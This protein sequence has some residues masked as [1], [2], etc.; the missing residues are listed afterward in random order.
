MLD[1]DTLMTYIVGRATSVLFFNFFGGFE[2]KYTLASEQP[3][4]TKDGFLA[5]HWKTK[6]QQVD[7]GDS[8]SV[9][10]IHRDTGKV[11]EIV[12]TILDVRENG[13]ISE[14]QTL[15]YL[16]QM[17]LSEP[18]VSQASFGKTVIW[19]ATDQIKKLN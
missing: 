8:V 3:E 17:E 9:F 16:F 6:K 1:K 10:Q 18:S 13:V 5:K 15:C 19:I 2:M 4:K 14:T 11:S 12:G 7:L